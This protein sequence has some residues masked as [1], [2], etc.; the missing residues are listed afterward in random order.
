[1]GVVQVSG[2]PSFFGSML[3]I[4]GIGALIERGSQYD[5]KFGLD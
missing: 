4:C 1:M 5:I 2:S 3:A